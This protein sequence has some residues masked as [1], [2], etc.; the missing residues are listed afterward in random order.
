MDDPNRNLDHTPVHNS[1]GNPDN[2]YGHSAD[3]I[4]GIRQIWPL[5]S[6]VLRLLPRTTPGLKLEFSFS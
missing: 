3:E 6:E 1:R 4:L 5:P 2:S